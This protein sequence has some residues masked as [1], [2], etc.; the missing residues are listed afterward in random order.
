MWV[1]S[2]KRKKFGIKTV[3]DDEPKC[4]WDVHSAGDL[5]MH[6]GEFNGNIGRHI[7]GFD[8]DHG[9]YCVGQRNLDE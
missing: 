9:G 8:W 6:V 2:A 1:C 4:E 7:D 3:F 5:V